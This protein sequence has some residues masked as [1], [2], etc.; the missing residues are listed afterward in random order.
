VAAQ[1]TFGSHRFN[2]SG[3]EIFRGPLIPKNIFQYSEKQFK[4]AWDLASTDFDTTVQSFKLWPSASGISSPT[5]SS[6]TEDLAEFFDLMASQNNSWLDQTNYSISEDDALTNFDQEFAADPFA[7]DGDPSVP[8]SGTSFFNLPELDESFLIDEILKEKEVVTT[9]LTST[10]ADEPC[11]FLISDPEVQEAFRKFNVAEL[12]GNM[13]MVNPSVISPGT[14]EEPTSHLPELQPQQQPKRSRRKSQQV[15]RVAESPFPIH[16]DEEELSN[17]ATETKPNVTALGLLNGNSSRG[18]KR[19]QNTANEQ[20]TS[21]GQKRKRKYELDAPEDPSVKNAKAA[22]LNR[23]KKKQEMQELK[24]TVQTIQKENEELKQQMKVLMERNDEV[25][26]K[27]QQ[28][29]EKNLVN[30]GLV[31]QLTNAKKILELIVPP[32]VNNLGP[33]NVTVSDAFASIPVRTDAQNNILISDLQATQDASFTGADAVS[34]YTTFHISPQERNIKVDYD[35]RCNKSSNML[36]KRQDLCGKE[37]LGG[38]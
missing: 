12:M 33:M 31:G 32:L 11:N 17:F 14:E 3:E 8:G 19:V 36:G 26:L 35:P 21:N 38:D 5:I 34:T 27:Y 9:N 30:N 4:Q 6:S 22:K 20:S 1:Q 15:S 2:Y 13:D 23:D 28:E 10:V 29:K 18:R 7:L 25:M 24:Q 37:I 16:E